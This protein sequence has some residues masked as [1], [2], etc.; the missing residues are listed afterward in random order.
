[1]PWKVEKR[2]EKF[3]VVSKENGDVEG[4]HD[5]RSEAEAQ[6][7]ALYASEDDSNPRADKASRMYKKARAPR[8][9]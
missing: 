1:M 7:R 6:V 5:T 3:A 2:G 9:G 4:T 8:Q